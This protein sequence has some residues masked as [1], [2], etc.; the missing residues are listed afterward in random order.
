M[1]PPTGLESSVPKPST[2]RSKTSKPT[3]STAHDWIIQSRDRTQ[4]GMNDVGDGRQYTTLHSKITCHESGK[5]LCG[6]FSEPERDILPKTH[7]RPR[8]QPIDGHNKAHRKPDHAPNKRCNQ[9]GPKGP[10]EGA[11][12][13]E[14]GI[15]EQD[16]RPHEHQNIEYYT[17]HAARPERPH[18]SRG[19]GQDQRENEQCKHRFHPEIQAPGDALGVS[20]KRITRSAHS[21][22]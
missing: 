3:K 17:P 8:S 6:S 2:A 4:P 12:H 18:C 11:R 21:S 22:L 10:L 20:Q 1:R 5:P 16:R 13:R 19:E 7:S 14:G 9:L 15:G